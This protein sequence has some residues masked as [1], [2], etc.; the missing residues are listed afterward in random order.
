MV[1]YVV[2]IDPDNPGGRLEI[3]IRN[4][5]SAWS[6]VGTSKRLTTKTQ[7]LKKLRA[8]GGGGQAKRTGSATLLLHVILP[9][10]L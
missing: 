4:I 9:S 3:R 7:L 8:G 5:G 10:T 6:C 2:K 1:R